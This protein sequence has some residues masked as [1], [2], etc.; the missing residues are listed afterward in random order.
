MGMVLLLTLFRGWLRAELL[1]SRDIVEQSTCHLYGD[2][3]LFCPPVDNITRPLG[4]LDSV[5]SERMV[6]KRK[7]ARLAYY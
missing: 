5:P 4:R 2:R 7:I 1:C 6:E 3:F